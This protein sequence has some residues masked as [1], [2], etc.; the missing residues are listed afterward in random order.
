MIDPWAGCGMRGWVLLVLLVCLALPLVNGCSS[1]PECL[2]APYLPHC[3][4]DEEEE[5]SEDT[6]TQT[7]VREPARAEDIT[8][9]MAALRQSRVGTD[10]ATVEERHRYLTKIRRSL[11]GRRHDVVYGEA[12]CHRRIDA[13]H[14]AS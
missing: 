6:A 4:D 14:Q 5:K 9:L 2:A 10:G 7:S 13:V 12:G 11:H 1:D 8:P 3:F